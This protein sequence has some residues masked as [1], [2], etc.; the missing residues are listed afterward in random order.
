MK[1]FKVN[2]GIKLVLTFYFSM[3]VIAAIASYFSLSLGSKSMWMFML[4]IGVIFLFIFTLNM[5]IYPRKVYVDKEFFRLV[6]FYKGNRAIKILREEMEVE[7]QK[8]IYILRFMT[9]RNLKKSYYIRQK[10]IPQELEQI[11]KGMLSD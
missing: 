1:E 6:M 2:K 11:L 5:T 10:N 9:E 3:W 7:K 8:G 4:I